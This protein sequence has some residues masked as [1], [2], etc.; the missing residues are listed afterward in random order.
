MRTFPYAAKTHWT[1][2]LKP[3]I[4][5]VKRDSIKRNNFVSIILFIVP[6]KHE[7]NV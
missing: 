2:F 6:P 1:D 5:Q 4:F 3:I 7:E